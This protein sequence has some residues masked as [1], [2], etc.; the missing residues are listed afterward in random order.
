MNI[1]VEANGDMEIS[2]SNK[3]ERTKIARQFIER[4]QTFRAESEFI[5]S[6][7]E[8]IGYKQVKPE[9]CGALTSASLIT[10]GKDVWGDMQYAVTSFLETLVAGGTVTW[11]KG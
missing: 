3:R 11:T 8:P 6:Y 4:L 9:D 5:H 2:C 7:L 1:R 10:D